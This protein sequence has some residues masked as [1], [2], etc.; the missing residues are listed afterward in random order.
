MRSLAL[1]P[2]LA[3]ATPS[4]IDWNAY[5]AEIA[6]ELR[7]MTGRAVAVDGGIDVAILPTPKLSVRKAR[8]AN[9]EGA[10]DAE[11]VR[12]DALDLRIAFWPLLS[13]KVVVQSVV[14]RGAD[15]RLERLA[16]GRENWAF[17]KPGAKQKP[18]SKTARPVE[19]TAIEVGQH[20][21]VVR[22]QGTVR[23]ARQIVLQPE[24]TG[25]VTWCSDEL[26]PG[27]RLKRGQPL[28]RINPRE[29]TVPRGQIGLASPALET[30]Q[31]IDA[32][33]DERQGSVD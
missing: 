31:A 8:L 21:V 23:A 24:I 5:R 3:V 4:F 13:G 7:N 2:G 19:V 14:V 29:P 26:V 17:T 32:R 9:L 16:D 11:M 33:L 12:L 10:R 1:A 6:G 22:A 27:G 28:V 20:P 15:I 25:R 18:D 30:L